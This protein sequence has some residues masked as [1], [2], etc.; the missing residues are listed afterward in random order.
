M[1][2]KVQY[3]DLR[4]FLSIVDSMGELKTISHVDWDKEMGAITEIVYR[5]KPID[6]PALLFDKIPGYPETYRCLYR[7]HITDGVADGLSGKDERDGTHCTPF[8]HIRSCHGE[9]A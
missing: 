5:E 4:E 8:R 9:R 7:R 6:S 3:R 1:K 2:R